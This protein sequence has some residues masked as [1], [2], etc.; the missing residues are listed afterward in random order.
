[1]KKLGLIILLIFG[2]LEG[3]ANCATGLVD[4][5]VVQSV[6]VDL[7]GNIVVC[8][9]AIVDPD[10]DYYQ[11]V[12]V[13]ASGGNLPIIS[14]LPGLCAAVPAASYNTDSAIFEFG[15]YAVDNC[16]PPNQSSGGNPDYHNTMLLKDSF[17]VCASS[18]ILKWNAYDDFASGTDVLYN[19]H[20]SV[21]SGP[22]N[23][24]ASTFSLDTA[25][26]GVVYG[27]TYDFYIEAV[28]L[29]GLGA[30]SAT[31][32]NVRANTL[33]AVKN[34]TFNYLAY[35]TVVDASEI[36]LMFVVDTAADIKQYRI[37][38]ALSLNAVYT[39]VATVNAYAGMNPN[40]S[41]TDITDVDAN[42][43]SY[44]YRID[45][46][47]ICGVEKI[48]SNIGRTVWVD[49]VANS[50]DA[51]N[52][53]TITPYEG[54]GQVDYYEIYRSV[55]GVWGSAPVATIPAFTN[56]LV[57]KD[58]IT[59]VFYGDGEFCYKVSAHQ[60][61]I[62]PLLGSPAT[63]LSNVAC[64]LQDPLFYV[65]NAFIPSGDFNTVFKPV[66]TFAN[67]E[68]YLFQIYNRRGQV[69]FQTQDVDQAWNG[70]FN[71]S[72]EMC[73]EDIYVYVLKFLSV[74]GD[75]YLK[76]GKLSLIR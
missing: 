43:S 57:Y 33:N 70:K 60:K 71:N 18:V 37:K 7:A 10:L 26:S 45:A 41:F 38:R 58:D 72:G 36:K 69:V 8:W 17:D 5:P 65:P 64:A 42:N 2:A 24:V 39:T 73:Q 32:N 48:S 51:T 76:S 14:N 29:R 53:L 1:M 20:L 66:L 25:F 12:T 35:A 16:F 67:P 23:V 28:E 54:W 44:F 46:V 47:D 21:N 74:N 49:V 22:Y 59:S 13:D 56:S 68:G 63:S 9:S 50:F 27:D 3:S 6:S 61:E 4:M 34:P 30:I 31:S 15:V 75:E 55:G 62:P 40:L 19:V 52:T 11:I